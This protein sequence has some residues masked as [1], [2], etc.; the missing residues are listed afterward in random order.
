MRVTTV[1]NTAISRC[2][3]DTLANIRCAVRQ[4]NIDTSSR[5]VNRDAAASKRAL[6]LTPANGDGETLKQRL[7]ETFTRRAAANKLDGANLR[8]SARQTIETESPALTQ[9][10]CS[11]RLVFS[12]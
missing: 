11:L 3:S 12:P 2:T 6:A 5:F 10:E 4:R 8:Y 1:H 7:S 9:F